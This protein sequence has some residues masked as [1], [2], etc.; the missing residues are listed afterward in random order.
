LLAAKPADLAPFQAQAAKAN[1][2]LLLP[3]YPVTPDEVK[4]LAAKAIETA[5]AALTAL[6]AQD[7]AKLT[8]ANTFQAYDAISGQGSNAYAVMSTV[9]ESALSKTMRDTANEMNVKLQEWSV[10]LDYRDDIYR[11][12]KAFAD[13]KPRSTAQEQRLVDDVM[14]A[15]A[16]PASACPPP[17]GTRSSSLRKE[18]A[19]A[20]DSSSPSTSTARAPP[21]ISPPRNWPA[22][23]RVSWRAPA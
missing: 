18:L 3:T 22:C 14:R 15:T 1:S 7:P 10:G 23:R 4:T 11:T 17:S 9:A 20:G 19:G 2:V 13:T 12:L 6:A 16:A 21:S 5:E 8:F